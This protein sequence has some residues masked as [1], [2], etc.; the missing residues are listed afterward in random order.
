MSSAARLQ[1]L[2]GPGVPVPVPRFVLDA[3]TE[4]KVESNSGETQSGF[5]L[6][7]Q[8]SNRSPLQ[9]LFLLT[10]GSGIPVLRVVVAV[11]FNGETTVLVDGVMTD[12]EMRADGSPLA[13][14]VMKGKDVSAL[15]DI[16]PFDGLPYPAMPPALRVLVALSKYAALGIVPLVIPSVIEDVPIPVDR[17]P[18]QVGT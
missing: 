14:M 6:T 1:L 3:I 7:F 5:E 16:L 18:R 9:T 10:G 17:I 2:I 11:T 12:H 4:V 8:I 13:T 15:M